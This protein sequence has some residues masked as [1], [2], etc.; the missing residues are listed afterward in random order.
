MSHGQFIALLVFIAIFCIV[1]G[2]WVSDQYKLISDRGKVWIK[3]G[4]LCVGFWCVA[5]AF[6]VWIGS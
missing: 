5:G 2:V 6:I 1:V 3:F 4:L